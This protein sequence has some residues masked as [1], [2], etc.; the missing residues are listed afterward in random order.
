MN[1]LHRL[2]YPLA[3]LVWTDTVV[4]GNK[5]DWPSVT[6]QRAI[7]CETSSERVYDMKIAVEIKLLYKLGL[8]IQ[9]TNQNFKNSK[10]LNENSFLRAR[11]QMTIIIIISIVLNKFSSFLFHFNYLNSISINVKQFLTFN[12]CMAVC[13]Q[14][15]SDI[16]LSKELIIIWCEVWSSL[17]FNFH[18]EMVDRK[19][20]SHVLY[21]NWL[22]GKI[23]PFYPTHLALCISWSC[24]SQISV[25]GA[26]E[27]I[28]VLQVN[29]RREKH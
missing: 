13:S 15:N 25:A 2:Q 29:N 1:K 10:I 24:W 20:V 5:I 28:Q 3:E 27:R 8:A 7:I 6:R 23:W 22:R 12:I 9:K 17:S 14:Q 26:L 16:Q 21:G 4:T 19:R 11:V 18:F